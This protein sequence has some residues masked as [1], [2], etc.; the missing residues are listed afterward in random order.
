MPL[1]DDVTK[2]RARMVPGGDVRVWVGPR[3]QF[4]LFLVFHVIQR[5]SPDVVIR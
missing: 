2:Q 4:I 3:V 1:D 5:V